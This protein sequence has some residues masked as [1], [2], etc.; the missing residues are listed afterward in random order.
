MGRTQP[1]HKISDLISPGQ[2]E[3]SSLVIVPCFWNSHDSVF[4]E[5]RICG[6]VLDLP[7]HTREVCLVPA[8][9]CSTPQLLGVHVP[10]QGP[11]PALVHAARFN[12]T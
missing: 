5:E 9:S 1:K 4:R 2:R 8:V 12:K 11:D 3:A 7:R 6:S 10:P